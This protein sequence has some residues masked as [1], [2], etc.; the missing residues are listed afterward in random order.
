MNNPLERRNEERLETKRYVEETQIY[1][2]NANDK[3]N[4]TVKRPKLTM[5]INLA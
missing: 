5:T 3:T 1:E 2:T 4:R